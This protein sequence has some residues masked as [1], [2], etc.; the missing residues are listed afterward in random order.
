MYAGRVIEIGTVHEVLKAPRHP[1]TAA[2]LASMPRIDDTGTGPLPAIGG[3]PPN[4]RQLPPGCAFGP[5]CERV[6]ETCRTARAALSGH[7]RR[8]ACHHP[9]ERP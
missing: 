6:D 4:P 1:Y 9:L 3:Q 8:V 5:R 2:L 7:D